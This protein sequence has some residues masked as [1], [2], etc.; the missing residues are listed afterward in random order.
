MPPGLKG[1]FTLWIG[2]VVLT[3]WIEI[4]PMDSTT[5]PGSR[6]RELSELN[7]LDQGRIR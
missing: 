2:L 7:F 5:Q 1:G 3:P 4:H 6:W